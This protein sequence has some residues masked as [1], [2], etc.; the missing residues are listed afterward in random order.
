MLVGI[1]THQP[2][3]KLLTQIF[4]KTARQFTRKSKMP[5]LIKADIAME[6]NETKSIDLVFLL[7]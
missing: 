3:K 4:R 1:E 6:S 7:I 2:I 5:T